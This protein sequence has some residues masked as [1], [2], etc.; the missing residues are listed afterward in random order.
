[1]KK[2]YHKGTVHPSPPL[3]SDQLAFLPAAILALAA[4]LPP[5]DREILAYL[6]SCSSAATSNFPGQPR[7]RSAAVEADHAPLFSC[8]CFACYTS[9]WV[10]WDES[11]NRQ[12]LHEIIDAFEDNLAQSATKG[13]K[14]GKGKKDKRNKKGCT[15][16]SSIANKHAHSTE[17]PSSPSRDSPQSESVPESNPSAGADPAEG[18][19]VEDKGSVRKFVSFIGER[20]WGWGQ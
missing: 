10:R 3:I 14:N 5:D 8:S 1:M 19:S 16:S 6:L 17:L 15:S 9:Y 18:V 7:R 13:K 12:L 11:P 20:I 4:A 2:L